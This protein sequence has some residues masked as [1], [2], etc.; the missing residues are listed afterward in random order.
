MPA[1]LP[2]R[3]A[4]QEFHALLLPKFD[5]I[6]ID[7][8]GFSSR[9]EALVIANRLDGAVVVARKGRTRMAELA[10]TGERLKAA[11]VALAGSVLVDD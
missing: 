5:L 9:A 10:A 2:G 8:C 1:S 6:L 4:F 3:G 7:T 11:G